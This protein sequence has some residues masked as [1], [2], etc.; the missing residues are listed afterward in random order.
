MNRVLY[1]EINLFSAL[2]SKAHQIFKASDELSGFHHSKQLRH[3]HSRSKGIS[4]II[5]EIKT[6][7]T[8]MNVMFL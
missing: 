5:T 7:N 2:S 6:R 3:F 4:A 8:E 1:W